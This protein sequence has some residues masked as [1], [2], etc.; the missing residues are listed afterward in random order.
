LAT[1]AA[2][3][4]DVIEM[5]EICLRESLPLWIAVSR[6]VGQVLGFALGDRTDEM[7]ALCWSD[8][9]ADYQDKPARATYLDDALKADVSGRI[10]EAWRLLAIGSERIIE[11]YAGLHHRQN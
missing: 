7:L 5:K 10:V 4:D 11:P 6:L 2:P 1:V 8:V 9:P 3:A